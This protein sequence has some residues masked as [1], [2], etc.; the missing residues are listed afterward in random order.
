M[1]RTFMNQLSLNSTGD[2]S[3]LSVLS[4]QSDNID[5][6]IKDKDFALSPITLPDDDELPLCR[7]GR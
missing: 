4:N 6:F 5:L 3:K 2:E 7:F 1:K